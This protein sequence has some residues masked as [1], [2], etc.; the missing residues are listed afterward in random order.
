VDKVSIIVPIYNVEPFLEQCI[1]SLVHQT[2]PELEI[3]LVNDES[4]DHSLEICRRWEQKDLRIHVIDQKNQGVSVA[5]NQGIEQCS[6]KWICF[7]DGDD[8]LEQDAVERMMTHVSSDLDVL[9]TDYYVDTESSCWSESFFTLSEHDFQ[10]DEKI[11]LIKNCFLKTSFSNKTAV[12]AVGVPWAKL[13]RADFLKEKGILFDKKL[14]KMQDALFCSEVFEQCG[15]II[16]RQIPTYHYRQND[17][18]VCHKSNPNYQNVANAVLDAF[19]AFIEKYHYE[20]AL[21][22]VFYARKFMFAFESVKFI[23]LL[24]ATGMNFGK[25]RQGIKQLMSGLKLD[26]NAEQSMMAYLGKAH[27]IAFVTYKLHVYGLMYLMLKVYFEHKMK[28]M[29]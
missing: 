14:R 17:A 7:V 1:E 11:E 28:K 18:S 13:F 25:K 21:L 9:I 12:T 5:R 23:Y 8:W 10:K 20:E 6:G 15:G 29:K 27:Q 2:Y 24:D 26:K 19:R 16:Y 4:P 3:F 22:P